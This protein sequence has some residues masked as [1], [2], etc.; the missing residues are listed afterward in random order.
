MGTVDIVIICCLLPAIFIGLKTGLIRQLI[1]LC[2]IYFGITLSLR[3]SVQVSGWI[4][5]HVSMQEFWAKAIS[6]IIIFSIVSVVFGLLGKTLEKIIRISLLGWLNRLLGVTLSLLFFLLAL[7]MLAYFVN[8]ANNLLGFIPKES[9]EESRFFPW[10]IHFA[11]QVFP[12]F[13]DL[14]PA[15]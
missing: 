13:K 5:E 7:S 8:S 1:S 9:L 14:L 2:V 10:L 3:F 15:R 11:E 6:F 4:L 12:L